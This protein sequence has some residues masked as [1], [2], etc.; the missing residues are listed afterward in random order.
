MTRHLPF[1]LI[2]LCCV[3]YALS[4]SP[5]FS[6]RH[7]TTENGFP[8]RV[9]KQVIQDKYGFLWF[10]SE[11]T[12]IRYD[13]S[14]FR[15]YRHD[16]HDSTSLPESGYLDLYAGANGELIIGCDKGIYHF[17]FDKDDFK[18]LASSSTMKS[19]SSGIPFTKGHDVW[20]AT[21]DKIL[22]KYDLHTGK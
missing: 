11:H 7:F 17:D 3:Q 12:L 19:N 22:H 18:Q 20:F 16:D 4:Q 15:T 5:A 1:I 21:Q 8:T 6:F 13:G 10:S 9:V 2:S 14:A